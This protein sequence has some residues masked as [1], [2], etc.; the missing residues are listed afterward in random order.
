M[1]VKFK[2]K[3]FGFKCDQSGKKLNSIKYLSPRWEPCSSRTIKYGEI[4]SAFPQK[5]Q[6]LK[7][8]LNSLLRFKSD[9]QSDN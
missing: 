5:H 9:Y 8:L 3:I 2:I 4:L 7:T 6:I 1:A